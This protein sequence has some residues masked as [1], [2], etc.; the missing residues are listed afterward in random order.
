[1]EIISDR[2]HA[3][4]AGM[5]ETMRIGTARVRMLIQDKITGRG[6]EITATEIDGEG[7]VISATA[8]EL[9]DE[10]VEPEVITVKEDIDITY[11]V[12]K[13]VKDTEIPEGYSVSG[14]K[15]LKNGKP[16]TEMGEIDALTIETV[17]PGEVVLG[18][19]DGNGGRE[20]VIYQPSRDRFIKTGKII[21]EGAVVVED[22]K[23]RKVYAFSFTKL[24]EKED[25]KGDKITEEVFDRSGVIVIT[26]D[27]TSAEEGLIGFDPEKLVKSVDGKDFYFRCLDN[28][29]DL[30]GNAYLKFKVTNTVIRIGVDLF[31]GD[32]VSVSQNNVSGGKVLIGKNF[33]KACD[34]LIKSDLISKVVDGG[35]KFL[36]DYHEDNDV[37]EF[38][39]ATTDRK[40]ITVTRKSTRDRGM[41][42]TVA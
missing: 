37:V 33:V 39:L 20:V 9:V 26:E 41:I 25:E 4:N 31:P 32:L 11:T 35:Y 8:T 40:T 19:D 22:T 29:E 6:Y 34:E 14:G 23:T 24:E 15:L 10:G 2:F 5:E 36:V 38:V 12:T 16:V 27:K 17:F 13:W 42:V 28:D 30:D 3:V 18:A 7:R 21:P 1:M